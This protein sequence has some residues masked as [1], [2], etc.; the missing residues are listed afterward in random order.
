MVSTSPGSVGSDTE[1]RSQ[2]ISWETI[3]EAGMEVQVSQKPP[4]RGRVHGWALG[5]LAG[6]GRGHLAPDWPHPTT[7][8]RSQ[9]LDQGQPR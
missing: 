4:S 6:G 7:E 5:S 1:P 8:S 3:R 2:D 9:R